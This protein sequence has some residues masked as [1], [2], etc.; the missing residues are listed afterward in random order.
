MKTLSLRDEVYA[1]DDGPQQQ[2]R[3][4][5]PMPISHFIETRLPTATARY[6]VYGALFGCCFPVGATLLDI[7]V[8]GLPINMGS[9]IQVQ[10]AQPLHWIIDTAPFF[11]GLFAGLAGRRQD[12]IVRLNTELEAR[13]EARTM[14]LVQANQ[15][16]KIQIAE[17]ERM[18]EKLLFA[19]T[20]AESASRT[21]SDFLANMSHEIR[22]PMNGIIGMTDLL[23]DTDISDEQREFAETVRSSA[24]SLLTLINDLLDFSKIE[25]GKVQ[26]ET[27]DFDL[28][29]SLEEVVDLVALRAEQRGIE[30][31]MLIYHDLPTLLNGDPGRVRQVLLNLLS[32][33]VKF[34]SEG[35]V[36][37]SVTCE[38]E[39]EKQVMVRFEVRDTGIGIP[40]DRL[41]MLFDSFSQV[42]S[43]TTRK[44][45]GTGLG[46]AI[47]RQL[48]E[49][50]GGEIGVESEEGNGST[51]WFTVLLN[52]QS[53]AMQDLMPLPPEEMKQLRVLIADDNETNRRVLGYHLDR[54]GCT[55]EHAASG[56]EALDLVRRAE[57][58]FNLA[59]IDYQM[60]EMNGSMLAEAIHN[61]PGGESLPLILLTSMGQ[62]GDAR[63]MEE[64]GFAGYLIKPIKPSH[65]RDCIAL[66]LGAG[67]QPD[68]SYRTESKPAPLITRHKVNEMQQSRV[69]ILVVEDNPVN[70][71]V[72]THI[73]RKAGFQCDVA[74]N[75]REAL[76]AVAKMNYDV[77]L[78]DCQMPVMDGFEATQAIR[79]HKLTHI[80]HLPIIAMTAGAMEGDRERCI[81]AG[82]DD[83]LSKPVKPEALIE[84]LK[85]RL[86]PD[87]ETDE[88]EK[89]NRYSAPDIN[90][91][92]LDLKALLDVVDGDMG[93]LMQ[94]TDRMLKDTP[95]KIEEMRVALSEGDISTI[96][97]HAHSIKSSVATFG[98]H[99]LEMICGI[100]AEFTPEQDVE[101]VRG[102]LNEL[103]QEWLAVEQALNRMISTKTT[104]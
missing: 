81:E 39:T 9:I 79:T 80:R 6:A 19:K 65:L 55:T 42:D 47:S 102:H 16:L 93:F 27:I 8:Q 11:L 56:A 78:M 41:N 71:K 5:C 100:M 40:Q 54:W 53:V 3:G 75:G 67:K 4:P 83:Y 28:R 77:I 30:L 72:T 82:M 70:Q 48:S 104:V 62:R 52:K 97:R 36:V 32:N 73:L 87:D 90:S 29:T 13:V 51:F 49:M 88:R 58:P 50:M 45:G 35:E 68:G 61:T 57:Q 96:A 20:A 86:P 95:A 99:K 43:S 44:Y 66:V 21:K 10:Q 85:R 94:L 18:E 15:Y 38:E 46:L 60:P 22:T 92:S 33:A 63:R 91:E 14:E 98:A 34:T 26:L 101:Q 103:E 17:R 69:R 76:D 31:I 64:A 1:T 7:L 84:V 74:A 12:V 59:V 2:I 89:D 23:M 37:L 24:E 25:A